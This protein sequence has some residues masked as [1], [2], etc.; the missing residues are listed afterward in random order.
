MRRQ[1][2]ARSTPARTPAS[3]PTPSPTPNTTTRPASRPASRSASRSGSTAKRATKE[4]VASSLPGDEIRRTRAKGQ[5]V[6]ITLPRSKKPIPL[7][8]PIVTLVADA[9][10]ALARGQRV[11]LAV[12]TVHV[13]AGKSGTIAGAPCHYLILDR[14]PDEEITT[15]QAAEA[16]RVSRPT[17][18]KAIDEGRLAARKVGKHRR[19]RVY[20]FNAYAQ[21][22]HAA[23]VAHGMES[24]RFEQELGLHEVEPL[25][26]IEEWKTIS[27]RAIAAKRRSSGC[28]AANSSVWPLPAH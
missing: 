12:Q 2:N 25:P 21:A 14:D 8:D 19:V 28:P 18:I 20:D 13:D 11:E 7:P 22:E 27:G 9:L 23:R 10:D 6:G 4:P 15:Q 26:T 5:P 17:I 24:T 1:P 3:K 16:L